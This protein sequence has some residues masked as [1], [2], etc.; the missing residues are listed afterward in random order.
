MLH[1][2]TVLVRPLSCPV[3]ATLTLAHHGHTATTRFL[4]VVPL[5]HVSS[6]AFPLSSRVYLLLETTYD[7]LGTD[8][9]RHP[10][11]L[12]PTRITARADHRL[13][14]RTSRVFAAAGWSNNSR[15]FAHPRPG[16]IPYG[17]L[18]HAA[19]GT[20]VCLTRHRRRMEA[21]MMAW[22]QR[23]YRFHWRTP[24][25]TWPTT[26]ACCC[27]KLL[28]WRR[29]VYRCHLQCLWSKLPNRQHIRASAPRAFCLRG[30]GRTTRVWC[31][32][33]TAAISASTLPGART[34]SLNQMLT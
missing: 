12:P 23:P 19:R 15:L 27:R 18:W 34:L 24:V 1:D 32:M 30:R 10:H 11:S 9:T 22:C 17:W 28:M 8:T 20:G 3:A 14:N 16:D 33:L 25:T 5:D 7:A 31:P 6:V 4:V 26:T 21:S 29:R 2:G 13:A